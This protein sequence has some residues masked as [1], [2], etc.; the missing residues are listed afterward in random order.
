MPALVDLNVEQIDAIIISGPPAVAQRDLMSPYVWRRPDGKFAMLVRAVP[1]GDYDHGAAS[2]TGTIWHALSDDGLSFTVEGGPVLTPGPGLD[3]IG[4]CED[5]TPVVQPDDSLVVYYTGVDESRA[6]AELLY[7][8]GPSL[9]QLTKQ[10]VAMLNSQSEG[11][12]K[13]AT[14]DRTKSGEWRMFYEYAHA[15]ASLVGL[16]I[17]QT[18]AGPWD[19]QVQPFA[20]RPDGWDSWHLSTG[21]LLT[22]DKNVPIMFYNGATR[23]ARWRIGWIAFDAEYTRVLDRCIEP[24]ITPPPALERTAT[25]IAFAASVTIVDGAIWLYYSLADA[26]LFRAIVRRG[27]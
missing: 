5:P 13:E 21:P 16:A 15:E 1:R 27:L 9:H 10:G 25:D 4:G 24:L 14:V 20:P 26:K 23:D 18:I 3:D 8:T 2:D 6:H 11:N 7:A 17:G 12:I 19:H 22:D